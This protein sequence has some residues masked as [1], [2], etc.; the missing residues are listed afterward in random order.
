L[1]CAPQIAAAHE[2]VAGLQLGFVDLFEPLGIER[3]DD[4]NVHAVMFE[5]RMAAGQAGVF[6]YDG[7]FPDVQDAQGFRAEAQMARR[8]GFWGKSCI[9]PSQVALANEV[10]QPGATDVAYALR[11]LQAAREAESRGQGAFLLDGKMI[12]APT[13]RRAE[14]ILA[15]GHAG[16]QSA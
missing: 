2:R 10:F 12:D 7:A 9:H 3:R 6:A 16:A 4:A 11:V 15:A 8:L 13:I 1:R 14:I 5:V